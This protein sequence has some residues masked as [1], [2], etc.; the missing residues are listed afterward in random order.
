ML[1]RRSDDPTLNHNIQN[2][3]RPY[4]HLLDNLASNLAIRIGFIPR[5]NYI[6]RLQ[7]FNQNCAA[8]SPNGCSGGETGPN[9]LACITRYTNQ[10]KTRFPVIP[11][12]NIFGGVDRSADCLTG[13]DQSNWNRNR[14]SQRAGVDHS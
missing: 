6:S 11:V 3:G 1:I 13:I 5:K 4:K 9:N 8:S 10:V 7:I 14:T 12:G 2:V